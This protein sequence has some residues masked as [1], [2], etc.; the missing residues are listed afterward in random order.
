MPLPP[1]SMAKEGKSAA[2][3][4]RFDIEG[5]ALD[6]LKIEIFVGVEVEDQAVWMFEIVVARAPEME[7]ERADLS[8]GDERCGV[9]QREIIFG[10]GLLGDGDGFDGVRHAGHGVLL[11]EGLFAD[12]VGRAHEADRAAIDEGPIRAAAISR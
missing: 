1:V 2:V 7:F 12:A 5:C 6:D 9:W 11:E 3:E 4:Q 8:G 10:F